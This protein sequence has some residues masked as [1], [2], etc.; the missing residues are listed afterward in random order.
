VKSFDPESARNDEKRRR[1][2][3]FSVEGSARVGQFVITSLL[4]PYIQWNWLNGS[5][6]F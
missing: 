1:A 3:V 6:A 2:T 5:I 4:S